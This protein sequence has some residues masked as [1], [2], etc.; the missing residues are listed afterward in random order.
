MP[1]AFKM[2]ERTKKFLLVLCALIIILLLIFGAIYLLI[3]K[4]MEKQSKKMDAY[5]YGLIKYGVITDRT[6]FIKAL[7]YHE[8]R[9]LFNESKWAFRAFLI[10][11][12]VGIALSF[13]LF[14][15]NVKGFFS[16]AFKIFPKIK[17]QTIG[18]INDAL[19]DETLKISGP[20]WMPV[21]LL[22]SFISRHPD[23]SS[24]LLY[25]SL[26]YYICVIICFFIIT[27]AVLG[28]IARIRR[29]YK[30]STEIFAQSLENL[31]L[32]EISNF[33]NEINSEIPNQQNYQNQNVYNQGVLNQ[34]I[35]MQNVPNQVYQDPNAMNMNVQ[36]QNVYNQNVV[37]QNQY[38]PNQNYQNN[39]MTP[40]YM[41]QQPFGVNQ[42]YQNQNIPNQNYINQNIQSQSIPVQTPQ[43]QNFINQDYQ[44]NNVTDFQ[45]R[46]EVHVNND[47]DDFTTEIRYTDD[48]EGK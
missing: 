47:F 11:T 22:P 1:L 26:F 43:N 12:G 15:G 41:N 38:V 40:N 37:Y 7:H 48:I 25:T 29:G 39:N 9:N 31:N 36:P 14:S 3:S 19:A 46:G 32:N 16:D 13:I 5:M 30:Q 42:N 17:W 34:N 8:R 21:S 18:E 6:E 44:N 45:P 35:P 33:S 23:F 28:F 2:D 4:Y 27:K 24:P 20:R 10:L